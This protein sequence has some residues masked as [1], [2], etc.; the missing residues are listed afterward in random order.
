MT[1]LGG[2]CR[3]PATRSARYCSSRGRSR[4]GVGLSF[5]SRSRRQTA[6]G[7]PAPRQ[8]GVAS[9]A[10]RMPGA[11]RRKGRVDADQAAARSRASAG[12]CADQGIVLLPRDGNGGPVAAKVD[13]HNAPRHKPGSANRLALVPGRS[14]RRA[15]PAFYEADDSIATAI[16]QRHRSSRPLSDAEAHDSGVELCR[17]KIAQ[18]DWSP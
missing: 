9:R 10:A 4:G 7:L 5:R 16:F 2:Q 1:S 17:L 11:S 6:P 12:R 14:S 18:R 8:S 3:R 15:R 13:R